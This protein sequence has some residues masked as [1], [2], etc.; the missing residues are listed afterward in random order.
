M[1][2]NIGLGEGVEFQIRAN[3]PRRVFGTA[4]LGLLG[5]LL[6]WL[7]LTSN[8]SFL[9]R[10]VLVAIG[11]ATLWLAQRLWLATAGHVSLTKEGLIDQNGRVLAGFDDIAAVDRSPFA[12]KPS[13]GLVVRLRQTAPGGWA[14]GLWWRFGRRLGIGGVTSGAEARLMAD[15]LKAR[16]AERDGL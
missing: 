8:P 2:G 11:L 7:A 6:V 15:L 1:S 10:L 9:W 14:P 12:F 3:P 4:M 16:L 5:F 13:N